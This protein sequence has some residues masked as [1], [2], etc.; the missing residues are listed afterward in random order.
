MAQ[1]EA[2]LDGSI[3]EGLSYTAFD[4]VSEF[5][6]I[7]DNLGCDWNKPISGR[8][9]YNRYKLL[10]NGTEITLHVYLKK[11]TFGG[12]ANRPKEKRAQF[13]AAIDRSGFNLNNENE[14]S[15][16]FALYKREEFPDTI[17]CAWDNKD[18]G[19]NIGR[20]FNCFVSIDA[21]AEA[22][23]D[24]FATHETA[25]GQIVCCFR[26]EKLLYYLENKE[27]LHSKKQIE[28]EDLSEMTNKDVSSEELPSFDMFFQTIIDILKDSEEVDVKTM[29]LLTIQ[30]HNLSS[31]VVSRIHNPIEGKRTELGYRLA[32]ARFYLKRAGLIDNPQRGLWVIT[33]LGRIELPD[34]SQIIRAATEKEIRSD[35]FEEVEKEE[36]LTQDYGE[37]DHPF[38]PNLVDIKTKTSSLDILLKRLDRGEIDLETDFQRKAGLWDLTKQSRLIESI[39]IKFPLPA[40]YFDGSNDDH[41]L[42][43][44]GLQR[45]S[46]LDGFKNKLAFKLQGLEFLTQ[47][48]GHSFSELPGNLQRRIEEFETTSYIIAP[49]TPKQLKYIVFKRV[50]TGGLTLTSQEIRH[51]LNQGVPADFIKGL[52]ELESFKSATSYSINSDR[53]MDRE[54]ITRF[55]SFF[56]IG[57]DE[58]SSDLDSFM[59][60]CME[61]LYGISEPELTKLKTDFDDAMKTALSI[62][63]ND[64][65]RKRYDKNDKRKPIN[66][67]LFEVW[68][69]CLTK[70]TNEQRKRL[71]NSKED[72]KQNFINLL[73]NDE[74]FDWSISSGTS[75]KARVKKRFNEIN[76]IIFETLN[77]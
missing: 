17:I 63:E 51:A 25:V 43:V 72:I 38:D 67:A 50:N 23:R 39:L 57:L 75:D 21:V 58:Y 76:K 53:M 6:S 1:F 20:A 52:A 30:K 71:V 4:E 26:P 34:K 77:N 28:I 13:S 47:L 35:F 9:G 49:G 40:F 3:E 19:H 7:L 18:W 46:T 24:G 5:Q 73:N 15:V 37:I 54:Y 12:R 60:L 69:V 33:D 36:A 59:N 64:A 2:K 65:F 8:G 11:L 56:L 14:L 10:L 31:S 45:L 29:E 22:L 70:L 66:K 55:C 61:R 68:S 27:N 32:W 41:W 74:A 42:V 62:F 44:D 48:N 16:I